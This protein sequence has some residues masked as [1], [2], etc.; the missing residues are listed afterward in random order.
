[1][2]QVLNINPRAL[3]LSSPFSSDLELYSEIYSRSFLP[4]YFYHYSPKITQHI[5]SVTFCDLV[6]TFG[7]LV[8]FLH[9]RTYPSTTLCKKNRFFSTTLNKF[10]PYAGSSC[11]GISE[12]RGYCKGSK[13]SIPK[14]NGCLVTNGSDRIRTPVRPNIES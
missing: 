3:P 9:G 11:W 2:Y 4:N 13:N 12:L 7:I 10:S 1:M 14:N 5:N 6:T 8:H